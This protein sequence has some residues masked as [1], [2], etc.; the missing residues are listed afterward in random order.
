MGSNEGIQGAYRRTFLLKA[1]PNVSVN[2]RCGIVKC[3]N[4]QY[5]RKLL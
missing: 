4:S 2:Y 5:R 1:S 3:M